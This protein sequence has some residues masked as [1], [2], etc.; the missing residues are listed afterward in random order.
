MI[1]RRFRGGRRFGRTADASITFTKN[2]PYAIAYFLSVLFDN[3]AN[4][5]VIS[6][7][8]EGICAFLDCVEKLNMKE[9]LGNILLAEVDSLAKQNILKPYYHDQ[10]D[11][12]FCDDSEVPY[13]Y[14]QDKRIDRAM[15]HFDNI[16][17]NIVNLHR[18]LYCSQ[19]PVFSD[20]IKATIFGKEEDFSI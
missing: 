4:S 2:E 1:G 14:D 3:K 19:K 8:D 11:D 10:N 9:R 12:I 18:V 5:S 20:I 15:R 16:D 17:D 6:E 7:F 13:M